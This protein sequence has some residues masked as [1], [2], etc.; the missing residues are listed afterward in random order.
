M[1]DTPSLPSVARAQFQI[2]GLQGPQGDPIAV[3]FNPAS[4]DY[5]IT[6]Q[7][8]DQP[9]GGKKQFVEKTKAT[10][11]MQLIFDTTDS[12]EDV[13]GHTGPVLR[14]LQPRE[15]DGSPVPPTV[16]FEWGAFAFTGLVDQYKEVMDFFAAEGVPLRS[17]VDLSLADQD[18]QFQES[19]LGA[20]DTSGGQGIE[21]TL[22]PDAEGGPAEMANRL[23]TPDAARAIAASSGAS[24]LRA[25]VGGALAIGG[26]VSAGGGGGLDAG[27]GFAAGAGASASFSA[28]SL[29]SV[30]AFSKLRLKPPPPPKLPRAAA[31]LAT[32]V[33]A[34]ASVPGGAV[35]ASFKADVGADADLNAL[36]SFG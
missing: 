32:G 11:R 14:M 5:T 21:P 30:A 13:R 27:G 17:T 20:S 2:L 6:N 10:L 35:A 7:L 16:K 28:A 22:L 26:S 1:G 3:L 4:L 25:S 8:K 9:G 15:E 29:G 18:F 24:S 19:A 34:T 36:I 12:G 31:V 33:A 23:G